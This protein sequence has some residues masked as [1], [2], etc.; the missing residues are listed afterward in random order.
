MLVLSCGMGVDGS[1]RRF[2]ITH[3]C[4]IG[5]FGDHRGSCYI[6]VVLGCLPQSCGATN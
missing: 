2:V 1:C 4:E 5:S 3:T 6:C